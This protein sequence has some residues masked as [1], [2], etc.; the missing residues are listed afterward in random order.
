MEYDTEG[1]DENKLPRFV[2]LYKYEKG[3]NMDF[4]K[5]KKNKGLAQ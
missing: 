2:L 5:I 4:Y 3:K 1:I